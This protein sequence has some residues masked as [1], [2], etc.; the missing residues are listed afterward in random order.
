MWLAVDAAG[1]DEMDRRI[2]LTV[3][4][5]F[6]GDRSGW[7][8]WRRSAGDRGTLEDVYEPYLIQ[9]GFLERTGRGRQATRLA[10]DHFKKQKDLL[11]FSSGSGFQSQ[12]LES[13][14]LSLQC[15]AAAPV[16]YPLVQLRLVAW[17]RSRRP[18]LAEGVPRGGNPPAMSDD[19]QSPSGRNRPLD[20][21]I[22][23]C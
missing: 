7:I 5:K 17:T 13:P 8:R 3:I 21:Q 22:C 2:L 16:G 6:H 4:E 14:D 19:L 9:A 20:D 18:C 11:P 10:Y 23:A 15:P 12:L 1:L